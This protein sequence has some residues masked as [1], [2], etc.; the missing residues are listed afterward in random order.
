[1][2]R[3]VALLLFISSVRPLLLSGK[4]GSAGETSDTEQL[5]ERVTQFYTALQSKD[6]KKASE[7]VTSKSKKL[8]LAKPQENIL[9][10]RVSQVEMEDSGKAAN[11][12]VLMK[13]MASSP[14]LNN[15][16]YARFGCLAY[17]TV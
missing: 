14:F 16:A 6:R 3:F 12:E 1:M 17:L 15:V 10:F 9:E 11:V 13:I 7:F 4:T 2:I 8:F 5:K